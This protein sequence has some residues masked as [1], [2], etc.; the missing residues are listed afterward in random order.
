MAGAVTSTFLVVLLVGTAVGALSGLALGGVFT[1]SVLLAIV[2]GFIGMAAAIMARHALLAMK[3]RLPPQSSEVSKITYAYA[4]VVC[5]FGSIAGYYVAMLL[6]EPFPVWIGA[7]SGLLSSILM[8][9]L[10]TVAQTPF[11]TEK[12]QHR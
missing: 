9:P 6:H 11:L 2:A 7:L 3:L 8:A 4:G 12:R 10:V 5:L 1:H